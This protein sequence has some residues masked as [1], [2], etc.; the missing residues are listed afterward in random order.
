MVLFCKTYS[1]I[2]ETL[3]KVKAVLVGTAICLPQ[4]LLGPDTNLI[5]KA[6]CSTL[7]NLQR[8]PVSRTVGKHHIE[9]TRTVHIARHTEELADMVGRDAVHEVYICLLIL[10]S[11]HTLDNTEVVN[12][13]LERGDIAYIAQLE[14]SLVGLTIALGEECRL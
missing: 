6:T 3:D 5:D 1:H 7:H 10:G 4:R 11:L 8:I 2:V 14:F 12:C 9:F 13:R